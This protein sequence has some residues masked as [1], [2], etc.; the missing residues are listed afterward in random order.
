MFKSCGF[1]LLYLHERK[2]SVIVLHLR[3]YAVADKV[4]NLKTQRAKRREDESKRKERE[5]RGKGKKVERDRSCH[6]TT[7]DGNRH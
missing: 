2:G 4:S 6:V 7:C 1:E 3:C 5:K